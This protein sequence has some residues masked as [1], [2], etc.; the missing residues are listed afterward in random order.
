M[1]SKARDFEPD[2][3]VVRCVENCPAK[4]V[5]AALFQKEMEAL[6]RYLDKNGKAKIV[7]TTGFWRHPLD[8]AICAFAK[9]KGYPCVELGDLGE[10]DTMKAIGLFDHKGVANHPGDL[11]MKHIAS[12]IAAELLPLI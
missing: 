6:L 3:I 10:D 11:G 8:E 4:D 7:M 5:D 2:V 1:Y 9:E 12:R